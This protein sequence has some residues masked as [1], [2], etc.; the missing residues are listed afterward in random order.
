MFS[1]SGEKSFSLIDI[2]MRIDYTSYAKCINL[3]GVRP[4]RNRKRFGKE[5]PN[6]K[7]KYEDLKMEVVAFEDDILTGQGVRDNIPASAQTV[8]LTPVGQG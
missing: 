4:R 7:E 8:T 2:T 3:R 1:R 6:M 5:L